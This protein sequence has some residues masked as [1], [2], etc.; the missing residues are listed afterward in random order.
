[1]YYDFIKQGYRVNN[2]MQYFIYLTI[3]H[4]YFLRK[5]ACVV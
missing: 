2:F 5:F 1:M 4:K 3:W